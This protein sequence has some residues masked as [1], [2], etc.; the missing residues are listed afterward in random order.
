MSMM[1]RRRMMAGGGALFATLTGNPVSFT[2]QRSAPLKTLTAS[3]S[4]VQSGSGDPSPDNVRPFTG[5]TECNIWVEATHDTSAAAT[6]TFLVGKNLFDMSAAVDGYLTS[7][8]TTILTSSAQDKVSWFIPVV[9][10]QTYTY[11]QY[12]SQVGAGY[13]TGYAFYSAEDMST[14]IGSRNTSTGTTTV[15]FTVPEGANYV[16]IG[17]RY[18]KSGKAQLELGSSSTTYEDYI[19]GPYYGGTINVLTGVLTVDKVALTIDGDTVQANVKLQ[20]GELMR[21]G[22]P[23]PSGLEAKYSGES[24]Y[25]I[26]DKLTPS[27]TNTVG[28]SSSATA[29]YYTFP[30]SSALF[31]SLPADAYSTV[32]LANAW[33][34]E[35]TPTV[36]YE[37]ATPKTYQL[38]AQQVSALQGDNVV[39]SNMN[40]DLT[41][42]YAYP[43][44]NPD[45]PLVGLGKVGQ[46]KIS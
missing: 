4:P 3:F 10:G 29:G 13:W 34:A 19:C 5:W 35:N 42:E 43:T 17:S 18:L 11:T 28:A 21:F 2:T 16:R 44:E 45:S 41:V 46:M 9:E 40:G 27:Y 24:S 37:L 15:T 26:A 30:H 23:Y 8:G 36:C 7:T 12:P 6:A 32:D 1:L 39:W 25:C 20:Y 31:V 22:I 33:F 14:V 38:T